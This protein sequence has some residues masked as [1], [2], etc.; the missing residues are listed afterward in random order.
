MNINDIVQIGGVLLALILCVWWVISTVRNNR[1]NK[2]NKCSGCDLSEFCKT[3]TKTKCR[4]E[5]R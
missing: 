5:N 3:N 2:Y 1:R 4:D